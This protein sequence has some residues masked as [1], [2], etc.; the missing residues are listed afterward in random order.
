MTTAHH[1][2]LAASLTFGIGAGELA[3]RKTFD[4]ALDEAR[5]IARVHRC[6]AFVYRRTDGSL[7]ASQLEA[8]LLPAGAGAKRIA[9]VR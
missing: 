7:M 4:Q 2:A 9:R 5:D 1:R 8:E 6:R 3:R